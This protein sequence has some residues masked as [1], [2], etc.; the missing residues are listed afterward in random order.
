[1]GRSG[2]VGRVGSSGGW[3]GPAIAFQANRSGRREHRDG[4]RRCGGYGL[5]RAQSSGTLLDEGGARRVMEGHAKALGR[6][7]PASPA[8][9]LG[10]V[11]EAARASAWALALLTAVVLAL[12]LTSLSRSLFN[13]ET[14]S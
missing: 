13:D 2:S 5:P 9:P 12:R 6:E 10:G 3:G 8:R 14:F 4:V 11:L 7:T 1:T